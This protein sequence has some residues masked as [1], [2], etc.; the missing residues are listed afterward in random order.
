MKTCN[1]HIAEFCARPNRQGIRFTCRPTVPVRNLLPLRNLRAECPRLVP[2]RWGTVCRLR[3]SVP[4]LSWPATRR[5]GRER[6][7]VFNF[8][9]PSPVPVVSPMKKIHRWHAFT[10][11]RET[12]AKERSQ[13]AAEPEYHVPGHVP[14]T[15][16]CS[17]PLPTCLPPTRSTGCPGV[18]ACHPADSVVSRKY[19]SVGNG[20][21]AIPFGWNYR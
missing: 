8:C 7:K 6:E 4:C 16:L 14:P 20:L 1:Y 10:P 11:A 17:R 2:H 15:C 21:R 9:P 3:K 5:C 13:P 19:R 18:K 12:W